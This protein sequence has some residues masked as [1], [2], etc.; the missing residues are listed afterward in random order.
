MAG[1]VVRWGTGKDD[2]SHRREVLEIGKGGGVQAGFWGERIV[3]QV[4]RA[5]A[6]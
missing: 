1:Q 3:K 4:P 5:L 6:W 2:L